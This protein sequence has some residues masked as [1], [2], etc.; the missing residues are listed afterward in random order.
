MAAKRRADRGGRDLNP[1][2]L[3]LALDPL[4]A[5]GEVLPG[6]ADDQLLHLLVQWPARPAVRVG[7]GT[8]GFCGNI[9][10]GAVAD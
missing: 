7:P 4:V 3:Q 8:G 9:T 5:P 10:S 6:Q 1:E 2:V